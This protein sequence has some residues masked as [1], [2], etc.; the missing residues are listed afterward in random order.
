MARYPN[1]YFTVNNI[2]EPAHLQRPGPS[3]LFSTYSAEQFVSTLERE[4]D[5]RLEAAVAGFGPLIEAHPNRFLWGTDLVEPSHFEQQV[6][7]ELVSFARAFFGRLDPVLAEQVAYRNAQTFL[8]LISGASSQATAP[9]AA[10]SS[11]LIH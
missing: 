6:L 10:S 8:T 9:G 4:F 1:V 3:L 5:D 2:F 7:D 11:R